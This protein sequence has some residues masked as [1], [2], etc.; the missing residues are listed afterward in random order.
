MSTGS[1]STC[2]AAGLDEDRSRNERGSFEDEGGEG[3][4][5]GL[6][7]YVAREEEEAERGGGRG[8][9]C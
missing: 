7:A 6:D 1:L 5:D 9:R 3:W 8:G 2:R 4:I